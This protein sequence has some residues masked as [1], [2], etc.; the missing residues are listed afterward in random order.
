ML[1]IIDELPP[2][3]FEAYPEFV[4]HVWRSIVQIYGEVKAGIIWY[5]TVVP[6]L[7]ENISDVQ[8]SIFDPP[9]LYST[10][11]P[12][13][14]LLCTDETLVVIPESLSPSEE[15]FEKRFECRDRTA[16]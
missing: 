5:N 15:A 9:K 14:I 11:R 16:W 12:I 3:F 10:T 6:W 2:E 7:M 1:L 4:T 8:Q 13:L